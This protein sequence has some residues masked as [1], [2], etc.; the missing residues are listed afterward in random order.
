MMCLYFGKAKLPN[1]LNL[2][3]KPWRKD[4]DVVTAFA[5]VLPTL[6]VDPMA[7]SEI[8]VDEAVPMAAPGPVN[9]EWEPVRVADVA[10]IP[11]S[12]P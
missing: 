10:A 3:L 6:E 9:P 11:E 4:D 2:S 5:V 8:T 12:V 7:A 1:Q